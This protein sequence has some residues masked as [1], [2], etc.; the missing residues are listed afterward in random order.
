[1]PTLPCGPER[2]LH[3][4]VRATT[5]RP[6]VVSLIVLPDSQMAYATHKHPVEQDGQTTR[7]TA[8]LHYH[9]G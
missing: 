4:G 5:G 1:M 2:C 8:D 9:S 7:Q 6:R 3:R